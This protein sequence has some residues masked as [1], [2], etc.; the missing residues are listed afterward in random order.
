MTNNDSVS[1]RGACLSLGLSVAF[2][3]LLA[4]LHMLKPEFNTG[5]LISEYQLGEYGFLMSLAFCLLGASAVVLALSLWPCSRTLEGRTGRRMLLGVG[6]ALFVS[7]LFPA[8]QTPRIVAYI[9]GISAFVVIIGSPIAFTLIDRGLARAR[10]GSS[11]IVRWA[12]LVGWI[13]LLSF[14]ISFAVARFSGQNDVSLSSSVS[15]TNRFLILSY[16]VW[17]AAAAWTVMRMRSRQ[18]C[19]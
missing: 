17:L 6:V 2:L 18:T 5:H 10:A 15:L 1:A 19:A 14:L 16:C 9:H 13:A 12:T 4:L 8:V 11:H 7:G 3:A